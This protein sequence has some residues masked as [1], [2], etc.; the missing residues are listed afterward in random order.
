MVEYKLKKDNVICFKIDNNE[1]QRLNKLM[2]FL[3]VETRSEAIR[4]AIEKTLND[5]KKGVLN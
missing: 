5:F 2:N 1:R 3:N 4:Y